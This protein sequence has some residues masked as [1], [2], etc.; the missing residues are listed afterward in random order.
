MNGRQIT[1]LGG[2]GVLSL[3]LGSVHAFSVLLLAMEAELDV[4]RSKASLTYSIAL[5]SLALAVLTGHR[6]YSRVSPP[7]YATL[8]GAIAAAGC[9]LAGFSTSAPMIWLGYGVIFGGANGLGYGYALQFAGRIAPD[10]RGLAMG[11][12]TAAYALG[13]AVLPYPLQLA[14]EGGGWMAALLLLAACLLGGSILSAAMLW[15]AGLAYGTDDAMPRQRAP[16]L[17]G[18]TAWLWLAYGTSVLAGLMI[19]GHAAG[20][21]EHRALSPAWI[22]AAP[23]VVAAANLPGSLLG[24]ALVDRAS[25]RRVLAGLATLTAAALVLMASLPL[26]VATL[27]GLALAGFAYGGTI[28]AFP[29]VISQR[30]GP[31]AG[32]LIYGRVFTAW[33]VAGLFGPYLAGLLY[34]LKG[35]YTPALLIAATIAVVAVVL[36]WWRIR[37]HTPAIRSATGTE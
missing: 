9:V 23:I 10:R 26:P 30:F 33:A 28:A 14:F 11:I 2:A 12:I 13:A 16:G 32:A 6:L 18:D 31:D 3:I 35:G 24:G 34:H 22:V 1:A 19:I 37:A 5:C 21:A 4:P 20:I 7:L 29:A 36:N 17:A 25:G 27:A 15:H 8:T